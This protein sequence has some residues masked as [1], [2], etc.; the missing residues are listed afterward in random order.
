[1]FKGSRSCDLEFEM[2]PVMGVNEEATETAF[3]LTDI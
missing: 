2:S 3:N 1:M